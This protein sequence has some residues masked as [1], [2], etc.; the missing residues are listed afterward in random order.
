MRMNIPP[1]GY[2]N[3]VSLVTSICDPSSCFEKVRCD[4]L[5]EENDFLLIVPFEG[6][7]IDFEMMKDLDL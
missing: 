7:M 4:A 6:L 2:A 1:R 5:M 3:Y